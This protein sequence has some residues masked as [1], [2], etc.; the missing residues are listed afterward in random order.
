[1][2]DGIKG[3]TMTLLNRRN[4]YRVLLFALLLVARVS[5]QAPSSSLAGQVITIDA[6]QQY[7]YADKALH[8]GEFDRA[9]IEYRRFLDFFPK[10]E[11]ARKARF[12]IG[13]AYYEAKRFNDAIT[14]FQVVIQTKTVDEFSIKS[15]QTI[16]ECYLKLGQTKQAVSILEKLID[17]V[18]DQNL[19]DHTY[20]SIGWIFLERLDFDH[21]ESYFNK[22]SD[23]NRKNYKIDSLTP[24]IEK[25][26]SIGQKN[27]V[28]AGMLSVIPG[29]GYLYLERYQDALISLLVNTALIFAAYEAF[30]N[31]LYVLGG[32]I[33]F[34][35]LG[36]YAGNIYGATTSAHKINRSQK[37]DFIEKLKQR[38]KIG[39][40]PDPR[41]K[42]ILFS[43]QYNF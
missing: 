29:A 33:S 42:G 32:I 11:R 28:T 35:E 25:A 41:L 38:T 20:H 18:Q 26:R 9:V 16:S 5:I 1:M 34:V 7:E 10:D 30:D 36:F 14:A 31:D 43:F 23:L 22:I 2:Y 19:K 37:L 17:R 8:D 21:A 24:D 40:Q 3:F 15:Y 6:D 27:P 4:N 13:S 39:L 12:Q